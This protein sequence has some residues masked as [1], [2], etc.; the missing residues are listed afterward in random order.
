[1]TALE[2]SLRKLVEQSPPRAEP[3]WRSAQ[4]QAASA[5]F[6]AGGLPT[7]QTEAYRFTP[8]ESFASRSLALVSAPVRGASSAAGTALELVWRNGTPAEVLGEL[9]QGVEVRRLSELLS[10]ESERVL[11]QFGSLSGD[12]DGFGAAQLAL[13][14]DAFCL[15]LHGVT[16]DQPILLRVDAAATT[17]DALFLPRLL[18]V[19]E[20]G[21]RASLVETRSGDAGAFALQLMLSEILVKEGAELEH[22]RWIALASGVSEEAITRVSVLG[23][24]R[25]RSW[26]GVTGGSWTRHALTVT[27]AGV[28]ASC[29]LDGVTV[30]RGEEI[31]DHHTLIVHELPGGSSR[32]TYRATVDGQARSVFDGIVLVKPGAA[33]TQAHQENRSLILSP[34]AVV[35]SKPQ[36]EID[37]DDVKCSHGATI[38]RLD[39]AQLFYLTSRG[40]EPEVAKELLCWAFV[41]EQVERCPDASLRVEA[42][43]QLASRLPRGLEASA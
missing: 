35:F 9:P 40:L 5:R 14:E 10:G 33:R 38:G 16:L 2:T 32:E 3:D 4:R 36:L 21:T 15:W 11:G 1:M 41:A 7:A 26:V 43:Q 6:L 27:L 29:E 42:R 37:A 20:E 18:V 25:Y 8:L 34:D 30:G 19:A 24:G 12:L 23:G 28:D 39:E 31:S 13:G 17:K 22:S